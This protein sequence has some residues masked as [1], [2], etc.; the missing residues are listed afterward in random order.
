VT[1]GGEGLQ[2]YTEI[3]SEITVN[4]ARGEAI[5]NPIRRASPPDDERAIGGPI[6]G[7]PTASYVV[8]RWKLVCKEIITYREVKD[9][10]LGFTGGKDPFRW[11]QSDLAT[12]DP[13]CSRPGRLAR[14]KGDSENYSGGVTPGLLYLRTRLACRNLLV[15]VPPIHDIL[16]A[17]TLNM[18][19]DCRS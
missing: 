15:S 19:I 7:V 11:I 16:D 13:S 2:A 17:I 12:A 9:L 1:L 18:K 4:T 10:C 5:L 3:P 8:A 6:I 14:A